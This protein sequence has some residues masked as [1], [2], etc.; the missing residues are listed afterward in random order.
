MRVQI[1]EMETRK[2][3]EKIKLRAGLFENIKNTD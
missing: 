1:N 3:I 2:I